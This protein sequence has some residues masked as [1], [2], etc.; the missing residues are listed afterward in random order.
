M[1]KKLLTITAAAMLGLVACGNSAA[2]EVIPAGGEK[3][4]N[5]VAAK[6]LNSAVASSFSGKG[7]SIEAKAFTAKLNAEMSTP[8]FDLPDFDIENPTAILS[9]QELKFSTTK[10]TAE[11]KNVTLKAALNGLDSTDIKGLK[12]AVNV[13]ETHN[14]LVTKDG[15]KAQESNATYKANAY[16]ANGNAYVDLSDEATF[17]AVAGGAE[18]QMGIH[19]NLPFEKAGKYG[20]QL[21]NAEVTEGETIYSML[22]PT[23]NLDKFLNAETLNSFTEATGGVLSA[24]KYSETSFGLKA[25]LGLDSIGGLIGGM[26]G[27]ID[28]GGD[29]AAFNTKI[30]DEKDKFDFKFGILFDS[31]KGLQSVKLYAD[32]KLDATYEQL[33]GGKEA[34]STMGMKEAD[35][36]KKAIDIT[37]SANIDLEFKVGDVNVQ[38]PNNFNDYEM[39]AA[40][41][42]EAGE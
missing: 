4:E 30:F 3:V 33:L 28:M 32:I 8:D 36:G 40:E 37:A 10:A 2:Q 9:A 17:N 11:I 24:V 20:Y 18:G 27:A 22:A 21:P 1:K 12:G 5:D 15:E 39:A 31:E 42:G 35:L 13:A 14:L 38:L 6:K 29:G 19:V 34:A 7:L 23:L 16:I 41:G 25:E 26:S